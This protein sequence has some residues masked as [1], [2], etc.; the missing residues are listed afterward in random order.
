MMQ[1]SLLQKLNTLAERYEELG[2]LLGN[3]EVIKDQKKFRQYSQE[4][5]RLEALTET[6]NEYK[7]VLS[8][9]DDA[10]QML[11]EDDTELRALAQDELEQGKAQV[12][13]LELK[14]RKHLLPQDPNDAKNIFL[15]I[16]AGTGGDEAALFAADLY[17]MYAKY[18]ESQRWQIEIMN[19]S[20]SEQGGYKEI[21]MRVV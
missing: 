20:Y 3:A 21:I 18:A 7:K 15:E 12:D 16:R 6:Y 11:H 1:S 4:Y 19:E 5:A 8:A 14:L 13:V 2:L 10:N 9:I 17:R